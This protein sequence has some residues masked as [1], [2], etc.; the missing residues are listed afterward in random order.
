MAVREELRLDGLQPQR[1]ATGFGAGIARQGYICGCLSGATMAVGLA[2]GRVEGS[3]EAS[4]ELV[5]EIVGRIFAEFSK[6]LLVIDCRQLTGL[7]FNAS[8]V[9]PDELQKVQRDVCDPLVSFVTL[10]TIAELKARG[11]PNRLP[12]T[13]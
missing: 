6:R 11:L 1:L 5:Y 9:S 7:D 3:D 10:L 13:T 2:V 12:D 4:K 8:H